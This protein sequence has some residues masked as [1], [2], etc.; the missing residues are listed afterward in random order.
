MY[1]LCLVNMAELKKN[2]MRLAVEQFI[3]Y[4]FIIYFER[5]Y[6]LPTEL[7]EK[8]ARSKSKVQ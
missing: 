1:S 6:C 7:L 4:L 2:N 3:R 8:A 5:F